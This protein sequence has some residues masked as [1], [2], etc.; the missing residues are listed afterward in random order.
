MNR[1]ETIQ[2]VLQ[3]AIDNGYLDD[4]HNREEAE[5]LLECGKEFGVDIGIDPSAFED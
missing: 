4:V 1:H 2:S 5:T 3:Y